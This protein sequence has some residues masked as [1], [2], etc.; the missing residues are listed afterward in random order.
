[1][2]DL[3][4]SHKWERGEGEHDMVV[5]AHGPLEGI[6]RPRKM[7]LAWLIAVHVT[8]RVRHEHAWV[9]ALQTCSNA[10]A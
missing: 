8:K 2:Q 4:G 3:I 9:Q 6:A 10:P 5:W 1:M 7:T